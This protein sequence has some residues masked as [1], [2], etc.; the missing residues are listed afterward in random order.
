MPT[1]SVRNLQ[2]PNPIGIGL[3]IH[4][5]VSKVQNFDRLFNLS[6]MDNDA[7]KFPGLPH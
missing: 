5:L 4:R 7:L 6:L 3:G 2:E 1:A